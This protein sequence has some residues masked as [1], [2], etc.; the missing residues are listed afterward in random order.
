MPTR[1]VEGNSLDTSHKKKKKPKQ[2]ET[3]NQKT[4]KIKTVKQ[5]KY[6][7][8]S[9]RWIQ[10]MNIFGEKIS[11]NLDD[12]EIYHLGLFT[13]L[14]FSLRKSCPFIVTLRNFLKE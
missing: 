3:K 12:N 9:M 11:L 1:I 2:N 4:K 14:N 7:F 6:C 10:A 8:S 5:N 13:M